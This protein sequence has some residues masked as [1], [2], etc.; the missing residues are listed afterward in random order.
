MDDMMDPLLWSESR[1]RFHPKINDFA[2]RFHVIDEGI[3]IEYETASGIN[4]NLGIGYHQ[5]SSDRI[6][7]A[8][9]LDESNLVVPVSFDNGHVT[10][11]DLTGIMNEIFE[12]GHYLRKAIEQMYYLGNQNRN[13]PSQWL[14]S[15]K[16][17]AN[18]RYV[19][20]DILKERH[21]IEIDC[22]DPVVDSPPCIW[23]ELERVN[24]LFEYEQQ[25]GDNIDFFAMTGITVEAR[26]AS[27]LEIVTGECGHLPMLWSLINIRSPKSTPVLWESFLSDETDSHMYQTMYLLIKSRYLVNLAEY[28]P[29][30]NGIVVFPNRLNHFTEEQVQAP[31]F[32]IIVPSTGDI[33]VFLKLDGDAISFYDNEE[34]LS[35]GKE[36]GT[37]LRSMSRQFFSQ[38]PV[39]PAKVTGLVSHETRE[40]FELID[41]YASTALALEILLHNLIIAADVNLQSIRVDVGQLGW[42]IT[43]LIDQCNKLPQLESQ[44]R[45]RCWWAITRG[46]LGHETNDMKRF[47]EKRGLVNVLRSAWDYTL[48][49]ELSDEYSFTDTVSQDRVLQMLNHFHDSDVVTFS[50]N[51]SVL[52]RDI[53]PLIETPLT[54]KGLGFPISSVRID[55]MNMTYSDNGGPRLYSQYEIDYM[56]TNV[57]GKNQRMKLTQRLFRGNPVFFHLAYIISPTASERNKAATTHAC[58]CKVY[59][60]DPFDKNNG[61]QERRLVVDWLEGVFDNIYKLCAVPILA[62]LSNYFGVRVKQREYKQSKVLNILDAKDPCNPASLYAANERMKSLFETNNQWDW[63]PYD[64]TLD[65]GREYVVELAYSLILMQM[66]TKT[67]EARIHEKTFATWKQKNKEHMSTA[68]SPVHLYPSSSTPVTVWLPQ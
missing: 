60:E 49:R 17:D 3:P 16:L 50:N 36:V 27:K 25:I 10:N 9:K 66:A 54:G 20:P 22:D 11:V 42:M 4:R 33:F 68:V 19:H 51:N 31:P 1:Q 13:W 61:N 53:V 41:K 63:E 5:L 39:N 8:F 46:E 52:K 38:E 48:R 30:N 65:E 21:V 24:I 37:A 6:L 67:P 56:M 7:P 55:A 59:L 28:T 57:N 18:S 47:N 32:V 29:H 62:Y 15:T 34:S 12:P 64:L 43:S 26:D 35:L 45:A 44:Y 40:N 2:N 14:D 58:L 23:S